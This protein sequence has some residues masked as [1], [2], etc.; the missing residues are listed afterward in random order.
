MQ[1][2]VVKVRGVASPVPGLT[3]FGVAVC[4]SAVLHAAVAAI[5]RMIPKVLITASPRFVPIP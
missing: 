2:V 3:T 4:A 5:A 1:L